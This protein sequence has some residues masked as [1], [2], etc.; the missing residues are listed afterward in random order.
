[1]HQQRTSHRPAQSLVE[2]SL[3]LPLIILLMLGSVD[4]ARIYFTKI[5][6]ANA[7]RAAAAFATNYQLGITY[8]TTEASNRIL[9]IAQSEAGSSVVIESAT[10]TGTW[11]PGTRFHV[12][13]TTRWSPITPVVSQLWGGGALT[14]THTTDLRHN[15]SATA[16]CDYPS[17][18]PTPTQ[19]LPPPTNTPGPPTAT[20]TPSPTPTATITPTPTFTYT[21]TYTPTPTPTPTAT[22]TP[23]AT[24]TA[25]PTPTATVCVQP[26]ITSG[27][28][29]SINGP[30]ANRRATFNFNTSL[31]TEAQVEVG[32]PNG[33][34]GDYSNF[35]LASGPTTNHSPRSD[36]GQLV[37]G[38]TYHYR[39]QLKDTCGTFFQSG[40]DLTFT[41]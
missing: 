38:A 14:L 24:S 9:A 12:T 25:T 28:T 20:F 33:A 40:G 35:S 3:L 10:F 17:P 6:L 29:V 21:P 2:L 15:C 23:T 30:S 22:F 37:T 31:S 11:Q 36:P 4:L 16:P 27:P 41:P 26:S 8:S 7:S 32:P 19:G 39:I 34:A 18:T 13:V 1:M 5:S